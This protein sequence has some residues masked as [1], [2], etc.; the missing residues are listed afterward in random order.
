MEESETVKKPCIKLQKM[1]NTERTLVQ[2]LTR[3]TGLMLTCYTL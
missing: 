2:K 3:P 1:I